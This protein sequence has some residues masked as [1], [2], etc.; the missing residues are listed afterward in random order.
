MRLLLSNSSKCLFMFVAINEK[1]DKKCE[2][3]NT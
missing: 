2:N 3:T 1:D